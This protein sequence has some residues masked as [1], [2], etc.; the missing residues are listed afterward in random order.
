MGKIKNNKQYITRNFNKIIFFNEQFL[1]KI[2]V[3]KDKIE[4]EFFWFKTIPQDLKKY[5][6]KVQDLLVDKKTAS[7]LISYV[8]GENLGFHFANGDFSL[9]KWKNI[10]DKLLIILQQFQKHKILEK[11]KK[12]QM[13][14]LLKFIYLTKTETRIKDLKE[15]IN[16]AKILNYNEIIING[17]KYQNF[18]SLEEKIIELINKYLIE[19]DEIVI[20]HGDFFLGNI[21][22]E[23]EDNLKIVDPRGSFGVEKSIYGDLKYDIA[24]LFHSFSGKYDLVIEEK[25]EITNNENI[26]NYKFN[27]ENNNFEEIEKYLINQVEKLFKYDIKIIKLIEALLFLTM[28]P[29]HNENIKNQIIFYLFA[30]EKFNKIIK[31]F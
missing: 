19:K 3:V 30:I 15:D 20:V 13:Q 22:Y 27:F 4:N 14:N 26:F 28:I 29:L 18:L 10:I 25:I 9:E 8:D 16:F 5:T 23:N 17:K 1:K 2:S 12:E 31:E 6:P 24:K 7:F 11:E 21:I